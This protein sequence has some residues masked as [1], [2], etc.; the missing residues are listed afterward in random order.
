MSA[1]RTRYVPSPTRAKAVFADNENQ[2][3]IPAMVPIHGPMLR[4]T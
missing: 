4:S 2:V 1:N 3:P